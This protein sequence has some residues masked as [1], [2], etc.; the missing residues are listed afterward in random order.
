MLNIK[1]AVLRIILFFIPSKEM[2]ADIKRIYKYKTPDI[3]RMSELEYYDYM[4]K[5][6]NIGDYSYVSFSAVIKNKKDTK[7]GKFCSIGLGVYIGT[8]QHPVNLLTTHPIA[9]CGTKNPKYGGKIAASEKTRAKL[10]LN[11]QLAPVSI[12]NDVF[13]GNNAIIKDG[14]TISDGAVIGSGAVVTRDVPPYAVM[15]GVPAKIIKY[16]FEQKIIDK[17]LELKWWDYPIDFIENELPFDD[18][19]KCIETL[20]K[21]KELLRA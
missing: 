15:A 4:H 11:D 16:R 3:T 1:D 9:Y 7:I 6:Y 10:T 20:E 2:R 13:I 5:E 19:N 18:I 14:V 8:S 21:N 12:G 17:L